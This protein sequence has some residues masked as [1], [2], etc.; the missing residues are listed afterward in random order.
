MPLRHDPLLDKLEPLHRLRR[1][2]PLGYIIAVASVAGAIAVRHLFASVFAASSFAPFFFAVV[3]TGLC[4]SFRAGL[5]AVALSMVAQRYFFME[6]PHAFSLSLQ[7]AAL[8]G[9]AALTLAFTVAVLGALQDLINRLSDHETNL[10]TIL[11]AQPAGVAVVDKTGSIIFAN[12]TIERQF[13]FLPSAMMGRQIGPLLPE[14]MPEIHAVYRDAVAGKTSVRMVRELFATRKSGTQFPVE[15]SLTA[16]ERH[17][18]RGVLVTVNDTTERRISERSQEVLA[19][20]VQHRAR[21]LLAMVEAIAVRTLTPDRPF[22]DARQALLSTL[23][24][25]KRT[26]ETLISDGVITLKEIVTREVA[27]FPNAASVNGDE[28]RLTQSAGINMSLIIHELCTNAAKYGALSVPDGKVLVE[29]QV[30]NG[31]LAFSWIELDGPAVVQPTKTGFGNT[32]LN[33]IPKSWG[34]D[35]NMEFSPQGFIYSLL[36]DE[37][38]IAEPRTSPD[39]RVA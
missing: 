37:R 30:N 20:E 23:A 5:L 25:F 26:H 18:R 1:N 38:A 2:V 36:V 9:G 21:N 34:A 32:L 27:P 8:L 29:W 31:V 24:T 19:R 14:A 22:A 15:I 13:G 28:V 7:Q 33:K 17:G 16:V 6:P 35:A 3:I 11:D 10:R 4:G 12:D 39:A